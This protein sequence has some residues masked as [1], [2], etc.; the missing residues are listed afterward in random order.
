MA[1]TGVVPLSGGR[2]QR[3]HPSGV[4]TRSAFHSDGGGISPRLDGCLIDDGPGVVELRARRHLWKPAIGDAPDPAVGSRC[5]CTEPYR[6]GPLHRAR[7]QAGSGHML[8][9]TVIG[10]GLVGP[11][12]VSYTHLR[13]HE[14]VLDLVC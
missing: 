1:G 10:H 4:P 8:V 12:P 9:G 14:T 6:D 5:L 13:A 3:V 7:S 11:E 2:R